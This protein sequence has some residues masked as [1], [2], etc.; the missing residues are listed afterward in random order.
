MLTVDQVRG[1]LGSI[2]KNDRDYGS[3][4]IL[5]S[6]CATSDE[7]GKHL[8]AEHMDKNLG[9][10]RLFPGTREVEKTLIGEMGKLVSCPEVVGNIVSGGTEANILAMLAA[11]EL[12]GKRNGG[13]IIVPFSVHY[14]FDKAAKLLG[15]TLRRVPL[16]GEFRVSVK[17]VKKAINSKTIAIVGT[18]GTSELGMIDPI[19]EL[20]EIAT[21]K[22][23]Y[24]HVDAA[25]G[26]FLIPFARELGFDLKQFDFSLPGVCSIT[27]DPHKYGLAPIPA[28]GILFRNEEFQKNVKIESHYL[29][30]PDHTT[31]IGTRPGA[32]SIA[33]YGIWLRYGKDGFMQL[34]K[35]Y[36]EKRK[37]L[38]DLLEEISIPLIVKPD[39]NI[40]GVNIPDAAKISKEL[41]ED[42]WWL[43]ASKRYEFLRLVITKDLS[44]KRI[45]QFVEALS[46]RV[47]VQVSL[48]D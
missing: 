1:E 23:I 48:V 28:G 8:F 13:E 17:E 42:G 41:E 35:E 36:Y 19:S 30:T 15:C 6:M 3:G 45:T 5:C 9:D 43:S 44:A 4:K 11:T 24:L 2:L 7:I 20:S 34:T 33:T 39:L 37:L 46:R 18:A 29:G 25:F 32:S 26:G 12:S 40:V 31:I 47:K 16:D 22:G 27:M 21:E 14:S 38:V 10:P